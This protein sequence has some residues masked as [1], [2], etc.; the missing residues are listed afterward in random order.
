MRSLYARSLTGC[1]SLALVFSGCG[2]GDETTSSTES[3]VASIESAIEMENGGLEMA[4]ELASFGQPGLPD[5]D[6]LELEPNLAL[7]ELPGLDALEG[8]QPRPMP[9]PLPCPHGGLKGKW[10]ELKPGFGLF[11]GKW[12]SLDGKL[13]C[14]LKGIYGKNKKGEGVFYGK[15][16]NLGGKFVGLIKGRHEQGFFKGRWF[17]KGGLRGELGGVYGK[18]ELKGLWH[19]FCPSCVAKCEPG[20]VPGPADP[21]AGVKPADPNAPVDPSSVKPEAGAEGMPPIGA[22]MPD[23]GKCLCLPPKLVPCKMGQCPDGLVCDLCPSL[24]KPGENCPAVCGP[25]VCVPKPPKPPQAPVE[26]GTENA[27]IS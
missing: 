8:K 21:N 1:L 19:A 23:P 25:P 4:D 12:G 18:G 13:H 3:E 17:D 7:P 15:Y 20:F 5:L 14:H 9:P 24:C 16:I 22:P 2:Q 10:K 11:F 27:P 26:A 6:G